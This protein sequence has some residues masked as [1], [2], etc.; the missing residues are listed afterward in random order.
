M[1]RAAFACN[2]ATWL[3]PTCDDYEA[4]LDRTV[5]ELGV[6]YARAFLKWF[7]PKAVADGEDQALVAEVVADVE[8]AIEREKRKNDA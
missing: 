3:Q 1:L 8:A 6:P 4:C 5:Q 7:A 2:H